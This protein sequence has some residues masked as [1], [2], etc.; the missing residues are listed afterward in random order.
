MTGAQDQS[1]IQAAART[2]GDS[3]AVIFRAMVEGGMERGEALEVL[4]EYVYG[5]AIKPNDEETE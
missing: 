1:Y 3:W 2:L 5:L 4:R